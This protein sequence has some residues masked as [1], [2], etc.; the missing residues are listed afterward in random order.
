LIQ[1]TALS[2]K[3]PQLTN[4]VLALII[5]WMVGSWFIVEKQPMSTIGSEVNT[6]QQQSLPILA[7]IQGELFGVAQSLVGA[8]KLAPKR[9]VRTSL[10]VELLGTVVAGDNSAAVIAKE[11]RSD[12]RVLFIGGELQPGVTLHD[13]LSDAIVLDRDGSLE[14]VM[15]IKSRDIGNRSMSQ[16]LKPSA[17]V[18]PAVKSNTGKLTMPTAASGELAELLS[19]ARVT[20]HFVNGKAEGLRI[21]DIVPGSGYAQSGLQNGDIVRKVNGQVIRSVQQ[22]MGMYQSLQKGGA[23]DIELL[24]RGQVQHLHYDFAR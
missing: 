11:G 10:K 15:M 1:S 8:P 16:S 18:R 14:K 23:I 21:S 2:G 7:E 9:V 22:A 17:P 19:K 24:R 6:S 13:V 3:L 20:P 12:Q 5:V 4:I